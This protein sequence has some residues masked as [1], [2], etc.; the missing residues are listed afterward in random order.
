MTEQAEVEQAEAEQA[1]EE[2]QEEASEEN[3]EQEAPEV[4]PDQERATRNGWRPKDEWNGDA[5]DW[6]SA[7]K[8]NER[9]EMIGTIRRLEKNLDAAKTDFGSRLDHHKKL[10]EA[11]MKVAISELESRRDSAI[12]EADRE[13]ANNI[14]GQIDEVR[15]QAIPETPAPQNNQDVLDNWNTSNAWIREDTPKAAYAMMRFNTHSQTKSPDEAIIA[16]ESDVAGQFP[17][18]NPRRSQPSTVEGGRSKPGTKATVK[19]SWSQLTADE[20][21]WYNVMPGAWKT[22]D[23]YLQAVQDERNSK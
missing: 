22:K 21:K 16:M 10:Q 17:D 1:E 9:G 19:L 11:Q 12:D 5:E 14:Q 15:A 7:K 23:D 6:V 8:F 18:V 13:K 20:A 4:N 2:N 3:Q